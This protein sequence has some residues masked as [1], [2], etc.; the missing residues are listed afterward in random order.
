MAHA[1]SCHYP[2]SEYCLV[3]TFTWIVDIVIS[4]QLFAALDSLGWYY[5]SSTV[6]PIYGSLYCF[7]RLSHPCVEILQWFFSHSYLRTWTVYLVSTLDFNFLVVGRWIRGGRT[8]W[9]G[10]GAV[11]M[12]CRHL[13]DYNIELCPSIPYPCSFPEWCHYGLLHSAPISCFCTFYFVTSGYCICILSCG[14]VGL[15]VCRYCCGFRSMSLK[16]RL[17]NSKLHY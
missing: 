15:Y 10:Y 14:C 4:Y 5:V 6:Y 16:S 9:S 11:G 13:M 8:A 1:P 17:S 7:I 2:F 12:L 3:I